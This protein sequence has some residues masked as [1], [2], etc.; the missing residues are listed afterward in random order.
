[1]GG[2]RIQ[3]RIS[4]I[5]LSNDDGMPSKFS[6]IRR[7]LTY[8]DDLENENNNDDDTLDN[9]IDVHL[10]ALEPLEQGDRNFIVLKNYN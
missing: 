10:P 3:R 5:Y 1:M 2:P 8:S 9:I 4:V 6:A 7:Y